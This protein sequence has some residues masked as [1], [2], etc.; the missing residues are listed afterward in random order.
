MLIAAEK[1]I[2]KTPRFFKNYT[3]RLNTKNDENEIS[4]PF[5]KNGRIEKETGSVAVH[6]HSVLAPPIPPVGPFRCGEAKVYTLLLP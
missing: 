3:C 5:L 4:M 1:D 2:A 6:L